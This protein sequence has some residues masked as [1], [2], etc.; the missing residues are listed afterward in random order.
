MSEMKTETGVVNW[1][2]TTFFPVKKEELHRVMSLAIMFASIVFMYT[3]VRQAKDMLMMRIGGSSVIP[4]AKVVV[5]IVA[6]FLGIQHSKISRKYSHK[7]AFLISFIPF[8]G[9][10]ILFA[11]LF[12]HMNILQASPETLALWCDK[13]PPLRYFIMVFGNWITSGYYIFSE[14]F[15]S[16]ILS[17][18]AWQLINFY[19]THEQA[20]RIYPFFG[21][22]AQVGNYGAG[23]IMVMIGQY[24]KSTGDLNNTVGLITLVIILSSILILAALFYFFN[25]ALKTYKPEEQSG[26]EKKT[27]VKMHW[28]E[29][30][31]ALKNQPALLLVAFLSVWYGLCATSLEVYWKGKVFEYYGVAG[32]TI[33]MGEYQKATALTSFCM[34]VFGGQLIKKLDW[35]V[36]A[37][38]TPLVVILAA[39]VIFGMNLQFIQQIV[40]SW[41]HLMPNELLYLLVVI[42]AGCLVF[43]KA[44]KYTLFDPTKEMFTRSRTSDEAI[45][46]KS[47]ET[48]VGRF[49]KGGSS[50]VQSFLLGIPGVTMDIL[51]PVLWIFVIVMASIW[52]VS[53]AGPLNREMKLV[54]AKND[55]NNHKK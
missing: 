40:V 41:F 27:K 25:V 16:F 49:G 37:L 31:T 32:F 47:L 26:T 13:I 19:S 17:V 7:K 54:Y 43:F 36:P 29:S 53:V 5:M 55:G 10:Y 22:W 30:L 52:S 14:M 12:K 33:F 8:L 46:I 24:F 3:V 28:K 34:V 9:F 11:L 35:I 45:K 2:R 51:G 48:F 6:A 50:V 20:K 44:S 21:L 23:V 4:S 42:G 38:I 1:L 18:S 39:T 15:G